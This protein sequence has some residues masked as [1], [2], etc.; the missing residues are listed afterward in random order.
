M[1]RKREEKKWMN[2]IGNVVVKWEIRRINFLSFLG[3]VSSIYYK[4][5]YRVNFWE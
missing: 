3:L 1:K 5:I 4:L 2:K